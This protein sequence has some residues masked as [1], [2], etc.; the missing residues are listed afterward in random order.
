MRKALFLWIL[1]ILFLATAAAALQLDP[2][3][4]ESLLESV[5]EGKYLVLTYKSQGGAAVNIRAV[6]LETE[7]IVY[8][9]PV[10]YT[11]LRAHET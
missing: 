4:G 2:Q 10:S 3:P 7:S 6:D 9:G 8:Q 1:W 5:H 11:H